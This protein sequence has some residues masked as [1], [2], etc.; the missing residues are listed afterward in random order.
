[1][2]TKG[3]EASIKERLELI[4]SLVW[5]LIERHGMTVDKDGRL[6]KG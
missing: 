5:Q 4:E 2:A 6:V 3:K 1:M